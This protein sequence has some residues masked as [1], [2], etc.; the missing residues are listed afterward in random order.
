MKLLLPLFTGITLTI[1]ALAFAGGPD[2][3]QAPTQHSR[4]YVGAGI[5]AGSFF[6]K[7]NGNSNN[8]PFGRTGAIGDFIAGYDYTFNNHFRLGTELYVDLQNM[9]FVDNGAYAPEFKGKLKT[10]FGVR[11][12]PGYQYNPKGTVYAILGFGGLDVKFT[13]G[14]SYST[15]LPAFSFGLGNDFM[16]TNAFGVRLNLIYQNSF[17][18]RNYALQSATFKTNVQ[19][20]SALCS[21]YYAF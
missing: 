8:V 5:G 14:T 10:G 19:T 21:M 6:S 13:Q 1:S 3:P 7:I 16:L 2:Q 12:M 17:T 15:T 20:L 11:F 4:F 18:H 9:T